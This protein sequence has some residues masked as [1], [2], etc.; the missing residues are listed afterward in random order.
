LTIREIAALSG[1][2]LAA[3]LVVVALVGADIRVSTLLRGGG[4]FLSPWGG[5]RLLLWAGADPYDI[6]VA[7][8]AQEQAYGRPAT[9]GENP[10]RLNIPLFLL[11]AFFP[12][13]LVPDAAVAR[14]VW[15]FLGQ[16]A[17]VAGVLWT[18]RL[19]EWRPPRAV[20]VAFGLLV[21]FGYYAVNALVEGTPVVLLVAAYLGVL[22]AL[23]A[24]SDELAGTLLALSLFA[25][26]AGAVFVALVAWRVFHERRWR[27]V[28]GF[29]MTLIVL[30]LLAFLIYPGWYLPFLTA[31]VGMLRSPHGISLG[32]V[33]TRLVPEYSD[34][35]GL[36]VPIVTIA[37][38]VFEWAAGRDSDF[39]RFT[40]TACLGLAATPLLGFRTDMS[41]LV[42]LF[43]SLILISAVALERRG[44]GTALAVA[45]VVGVFAGPWLLFAQWF[46]FHD[47]R[48]YDLLFIL[49]PSV[50]L[51]GLYWTRWWFLRPQ[52]TW[53]DELRSAR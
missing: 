37:L 31:T 4:A 32:A 9:V 23:Q 46:S 26:E 52:R 21:V 19:I 36:A 43:P 45:I 16:A 51:A 10:Y 2:V 3:L 14:G 11:P 1:L 15:M 50:C 24:G 44:A 47:Q 53:L 49:Y 39:R 6:S 33:L 5:A 22:L 34:R 28:A 41:N 48:A 8:A 12:L 42:V 25:W 20:L 38:L 18:M 7:N 30:L 29:C 13:A 27:V 35:I 40:W 17:L